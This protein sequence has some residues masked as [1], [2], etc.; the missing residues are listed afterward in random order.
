MTYTKICIVCG[1][2]FKTN[3]IDVTICSPPCRR[4]RNLTWAR[5]NSKANYE[6][7][8]TQQLQKK[9]SKYKPKQSIHEIDK[10]AQ[11]VGLSY[12]HYL[13]QKGWYE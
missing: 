7:F 6:R 3:R 8:K 5:E 1:K 9:E 11:E 4:E 10:K 13:A 12:G 2:E